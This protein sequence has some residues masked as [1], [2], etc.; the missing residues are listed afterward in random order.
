MDHH[1][2]N[3]VA[4]MIEIVVLLLMAIG[5]I[6][7]FSAGADVTTSYALQDF[8]S[9]TTL[10]QLIFFPLAVVIMYLLAALDYNRL[11]FARAGIAG[12]FTPWLLALAVVLLVYVLFFGPEKNEARRWIIVKL[13]GVAFSFQPS[14]L[15]KWSVIFFL[16]A[17]LDYFA[18]TINLFWKR[19]VPICLVAAVV[20]GLIVTQDFGSAAFISLLT[21]VMLLIGGACWWHFL[22]PIA[23]M[24]PAFFLV[25][26]TSA[27]RM[28]RLKAFFHPETVH[29]DVSY[30]ANESLIA[31]S[32]G[33]IWGRGLG[34]GVSK[35]L[36]LPEDTTD[37]IF[38]IIAEEIGFAGCILVISLFAIL[39]VLG[40]IVVLRTTDRLGRLLAAGITFA[41]TIQAAINI[42]VVTVVLPTKGIPLPFISAGGTSMLLCAAAA[43]VLVNIA[44]QSCSAD[45]LRLRRTHSRTWAAQDDKHLPSFHAP[46]S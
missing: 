10:K 13:A 24:I 16:A 39:V 46:S 20:V 21:F 22:V 37:F 45:E 17:F 25:V 33:R 4:Y 6:F 32:G 30:Q 3:P 38:S 8:Y 26:T 29:A 18:S 35:Y 42:G 28:N 44:R 14:E 15:A 7:V 2:S 41:L 1:S 34:M 5:T 12:S 11:G 36:H 19:F 9:F 43:G 27:T 23:A 31:I 40:L